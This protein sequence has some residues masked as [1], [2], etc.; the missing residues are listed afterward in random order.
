MNWP[1]SVNV[2]CSLSPSCPQM[3][4]RWPKEERQTQRDLEEDCREG[5]E[6]TGMDL[7]YL[8]RITGRRGLSQQVWTSLQVVWVIHPLKQ[9]D[10][11]T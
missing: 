6:T 11:K 10:E 3:D 7:G 5:T 8:T 2:I 9:S 1:C 4:P